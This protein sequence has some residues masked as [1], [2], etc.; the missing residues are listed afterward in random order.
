MSVL[1]VY[2]HSLES[3]VMR[4]HTVKMI[5]TVLEEQ[6]QR[7]GTEAVLLNKM[8]GMRGNVKRLTK[9]LKKTQAVLLPIIGPTAFLSRYRCSSSVGLLSCSKASTFFKHS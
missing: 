3:L 6:N 2:R 8:S 1:A 7:H 4:A 9:R 5:S